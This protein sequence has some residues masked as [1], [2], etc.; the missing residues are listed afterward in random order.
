MESEKLT[1]EAEERLQI[2]AATQDG[3]KISEK[4]LEIRGPGELT[5][6]RQTGLPELRIANI[7]RDRELLEL[8]RK[9]AF[10]LVGRGTSAASQQG[11]EA[12]RLVDHVRTQWGARLGLAGTR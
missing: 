11:K 9:E 5:G 12:R 10:R 6:T 3:F 7:V 4:D 2:M 8:A 1:S